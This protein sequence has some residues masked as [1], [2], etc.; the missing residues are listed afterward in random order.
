MSSMDVKLP[1]ELDP[2]C[3]QS[4]SSRKFTSLRILRRRYPR[5]L[6]PESGKV[7]YPNVMPESMFNLIIEQTMRCGDLQV[8]LD[9]VK[10]SALTTE[11]A[12]RTAILEEDVL[13]AY[14][15]SKYVH[16]SSSVRA[17]TT[18]ERTLLY[19]IADMAVGTDF[20]LTSV[21]CLRISYGEGEDELFR[22]L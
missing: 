9:L 14:E 17:L 19:Q 5:S 11:R 16:L 22:I 8:G 12:G 18:D 21:C 20:Y 2:M 13:E 1:Q 3:C 10:Q 7:F 6:R 4:F 15:I